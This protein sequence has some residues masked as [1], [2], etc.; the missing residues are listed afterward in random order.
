VTWARRLALF[1]PTVVFVLVWPTWGERLSAADAI[2]AAT[3]ALAGWILIAAGIVAMERRPDG[4]S[5]RLLVAAGYLWYVGDLFFVFPDASI[6][7][8]LSFAFRGYYDLIIAFLLLSFPSGRMQTP[9]QRAVI[10][11]MFA[12]YIARSIGFLA[13]ASPGSAY[14]DNGVANP[15]LVTPRGPLA[16]VDTTLLALQ[17]VA[18]A[19]VAVLAVVRWRS[20]SPP[21]R[22]VL[23]PVLVGGLAFAVTSVVYKLGPFAAVFF[24]LAV[25][26]WKEANWWAIPDYLIRGA[27][28]PI[29]FLVGALLMRTART[30]VVDLVSGISDQP[31]RAE[32]QRTLVRV[33]RDPGL[34][35]LYRDG[36]AWVDVD[37]RGA[38][39]PTPDDKQAV[40]H[41][42]SGGNVIA[43]IVHDESL[44]EDP[45]LVGAVAATARLAIDNERL[46]AKL[47]EQL[48]EVRASRVRIVE[49][50]DAER[51]R[52][53]RDL[54][55][56]AQQRLVAIAISLRML[57]DSL[58]PD[59][60]A[61]VV[62][63]IDLASTELRAAIDEL[64]ELA[65]G[66]DPPLL[67]EA[68]LVTALAALGERMR[69]PVQLDVRVEQRLPRS[70]ETT[71]YFVVAESLA[72]VT[73]HADARAVTVRV[74]IT[75]DVLH[76][77][78]AD[79]GRGGADPLAGSG[80]RG[81]GDRVAALGGRLDLSEVVGG[82]T[83]LQAEIPCA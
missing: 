2:A 81:L 74:W 25:P 54:H 1:L 43:A 65:R 26:P 76:V 4:R 61:D 37:G 69:I 28:A 56:G 79:N 8:L 72:N 34:V 48:A 35:V 6:V 58:G 15:F 70:V 29:G 19:V 5:G 20:A 10:A 53:E 71:C 32:L 73:K 83:R 33:L 24:D 36:A 44:L 75:D 60:S 51:R 80:L 7:P 14:P 68:G 13:L 41:V 57:S 55:D 11:A 42:E 21:T 27:A 31:A 18:I 46:A 45:G 40:T 59:A 52:I 23:A 82:G 47:A 3:D 9:A 17:A 12:L 78:V 50:A 67:R 22:R 77:E 62:S 39:Y 49:G 66:L 64:R 30:A 38:A 16:Q 63:E